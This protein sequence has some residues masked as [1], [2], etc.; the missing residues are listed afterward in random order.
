M[1]RILFLSIVSHPQSTPL[2]ILI[3][4]FYHMHVYIYTIM[5]YTHIL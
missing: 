3:Y 2:R 5:C 4:S 1:E